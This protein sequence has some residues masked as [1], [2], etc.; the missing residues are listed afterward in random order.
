MC[1]LACSPAGR[2][3]KFLHFSAGCNISAADPSTGVEAIEMLSAEALTMRER[4]L[5]KVIG[6]ESARLRNFLR[7]R[8]PNEADVEDLLQDVFADLVE[9]DAL[10]EPV[11]QVS[12]W[13]FRVARN[14]LIDRFRKK[15]PKTVPIGT[16]AEEEPPGMF[17]EEWLPSPEAGPEANFARGIL[18]EE[19]FAALDELPPEQREI[20]VAHELDGRSFK[21]LAKRTGLSV[22]TLLSRKRYAVMQLRE[23]LRDIYL[24]FATN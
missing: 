1:R 19:L 17:L 7:G 16:S 2:G 9:A 8:L 3:K 14:R 21:E 5:S 10:V 20:F 11:R 22:N 15:R 24:E 4:R 6:R 13:L 12:A 18:L 23:R